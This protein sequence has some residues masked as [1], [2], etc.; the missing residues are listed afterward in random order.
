VP[1]EVISLQP[2]LG[3]LNRKASIQRQAP[4]TTAEA[5]NV[6]PYDTEGRT[7]IAPR[8]A[9]ERYL[10][11]QGVFERDPDRRNN[12]VTPNLLSTFNV[13]PLDVAGSITNVTLVS[14]DTTVTELREAGWII[15]GSAIPHVN[16]VG[17]SFVQS[18]TLSPPAL[19]SGTTREN[20]FI[21]EF[22]L[23]PNTD[24]AGA[25][26]LPIV[27]GRSTF[28]FGLDVAG[29]GNISASSASFEVTSLQSQS[30]MYL[31]GILRTFQGG[32]QQSEQLMELHSLPLLT[33]R[34]DIRI[35]ILDLTLTSVI[36]ARMTHVANVGPTS[37]NIQVIV[38]TLSGRTSFLSLETLDTIEGPIPFL[39]TPFLFDWK[40]SYI[41]SVVK[42]FRQ[43]RQVLTLNA[44]ETF[45]SNFGSDEELLP[46]EGAPGQKT[47]P[48]L[49]AGFLG[50][51]YI[52]DYAI[53]QD[54]DDPANT[55]KVFDPVSNTVVPWV[56]PRAV[57]SS[58]PA[59]NFDV[60]KGNHIISRM[61]GRIFLAGNPPHAWFASSRSDTPD[62]DF[63]FSVSNNDPSG[64]IGGQTSQTGN[65]SEPLTAMIPFSDDYAIFA[66]RQAMW[67]LS[68]DP[69]FGG[70]FIEL[71]QNIGVASSTAWTFT[72]E[73]NLIWLDLEE[74]LFGLAPGGLS[75]PQPLSRDP[76]PGDLRNIDPTSSAI[77]VVYDDIRVG[78]HILVTSLS[79]GTVSG[80]W[81]FDWR[82]RGFWP[83][84]YP[85]AGEAFR[86]LRYSPETLSRSGILFAS[87]DGAVR[88]LDGSKN[89]DDLGPYP[90]RFSYGP[91]LLGSGDY[92]EGTLDW[93]R[94]TVVPT[95]TKVDVEVVTAS[96]AVEATQEGGLQRKRRVSLGGS[97]SAG[98]ATAMERKSVRLRGVVGY[99]RVLGN[100]ASPWSIDTLDLSRERLREAKP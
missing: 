15:S 85:V 51:L 19:L 72:P 48:L 76:L 77:S 94:G 95:G 56:P 84:S 39:R 18:A 42:S 33:H 60:P 99:V 82:N 96:T 16:T 70:Q 78:V 75:T 47:Q 25:S 38:P 34:I 53:D 71:S 58:T 8:P 66:T 92:L 14:R 98:R 64:A 3:G 1:K 36:D 62:F 49:T 55:P 28:T 23:L 69:G 17:I 2:P 41:S 32:I 30:R 54:S 61:F 79:D 27:S 44:G 50:K 35:D 12:P 93:L 22:S 7:R 97:S 86:A 11:P 5:L 83:M 73:G 67:R 91:V 80:S 37:K 100:E 90:Q 45:Y 13:V 40:R 74:G 88:R 29:P 57:G 65:L 4:F 26:T 52:A 24:A 20:N 59:G 10:D 68:G 87:R 31:K 81:W 63:A 9:L 21:E 6:Q 46:A 43:P 89:F